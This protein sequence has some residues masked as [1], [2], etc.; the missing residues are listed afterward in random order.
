MMPKRVEHARRDR[1]GEHVVDRRPEQVLLHLAHRRLREADRAPA[2]RAGR[3]SSA[4][5]RRLDGHVGA[6]A[7]RD[8]HVGLRQRRRVVDA[9][10]DHRHDACPRPAAAARIAPC[11]LAAPR[12]RPASM[13][14]SCATAS[15]VRRLSPVI[16]TDLDA[17]RL[18]L[19]DGLAR[20]R[21]D[22][23]GDGDEA[24]GAGHRRR[25]TSASCPAPGS[26]LGAPSQAA[27]RRRPARPAARAFRPAPRGHRPSPGRRRPAMASKVARRSAGSAPRASRPATIACA[28]GMLAAALRRRRRPGAGAPRRRL[29]IRGER[30]DVGHARLALGQRAGLVEDD[31]LDARGLLQRGRV[32][33]QDVVRARRCRCRPRPPSAW[34]APARRGRRSRRPRRRR[35]ARRAAS[36]AARRTRPGT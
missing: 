5:S 14:S 23:V 9:V 16:I 13:P 31:R 4:R 22:R 21:T 27:E 36:R 19:G 7:D 8:A 3:S 30:Y 29:I 17:Q 15:A 1:D 25:P 24:G 12:R 33:D 28:S 10:A 6:R 26:A 34:P 18:Q 2:C 20:A 32:L 35:S 11:P